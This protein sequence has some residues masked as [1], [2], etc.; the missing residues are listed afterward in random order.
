MLAILDVVMLVLN[1]YTWV[2]IA[3]AIFSWL[4]AFNIV[5]PSNQFVSMIGQALYSLTE[6]ALRPIRRIMPNMGGLDLSPVVLLI[7]IFFIQNVIARYVY[8]NVF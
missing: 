7:G 5:N 6:P 1:L 4:Y 8:P 3:S 2:I